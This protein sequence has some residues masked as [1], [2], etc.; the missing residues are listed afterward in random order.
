MTDPAEEEQIPWWQ[1]KKA[2]S[3]ERK[4]TEAAANSPARPG[5]AFLI[6]TEGTVTE[7]VYFQLLRSDLELST[8]KVKIVPG[9]ASDPRHVIDSAAAEV[10]TLGERARKGQLANNELE[11][12]D[13]VWA[14][15]DTDV[16]VRKEFWNDVVQ[17]AQAREVNLAHSTPCI[18]FWFLLHF[19][20]TTRADLTDGTRAKRAVE[21]ALGESYSTNQATARSAIPKFLPNWPDA[22]IHAE[23]VRIHHESGR[24]PS[25]ANPS[26][27]V[28]RLVRALNA[29]AL[30]HNRRLDA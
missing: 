13:H 18:E 5:D 22:V 29:A 17:L 21:E 24:T 4:A 3:L 19:G 28:D 6:V 9:R 16:A 14:V 15:V 7:P 11:E 8:V 10:E 27:E 23:E 2:Q 26:T 30:V 1:E 12:Y 20:K 25:P